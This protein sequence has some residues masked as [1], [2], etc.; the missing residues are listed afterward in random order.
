MTLPISVFII[1]K[2]ES[3]RIATAI[4]SVIDWANEVVVIDSGSTDDTVS[5]ASFIGARVL[6]NEWEGYGKQKRF[7][8]E[9]CENNWLLNIDADEEITPELAEEIKKI[10]ASGEPDADAFIIDVRDLLPNE[11]KLAPLAHTNRCLRLYRFDKGRFSKSPVH[12][13]VIMN[14]GCKIKN[15][16][17]PILHR[18]FRS[19]SHAIE[20]MNSYSDMQAKELAAGKGMSLPRLRLVFEFSAAFVK[21]YF[22]RLYILRGVKGIIHANIYAFGRVMRIAKY[23]EIKESKGNKETNNN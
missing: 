13:S 15:L 16:K 21:S 19:I 14:K 22:L 7:A 1:T 17:N 2:N 8:E 18:S 11:I 6:Y 23:I 3:D 4:N 10:F 20:K 12:D 5:V 9:E